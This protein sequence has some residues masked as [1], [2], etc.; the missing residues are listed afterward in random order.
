MA[1]EPTSE[2]IRYLISLQA[3]P[4]VG[5]STVEKLW[6]YFG[7]FTKAW[8]AG[9]NDF[10]A[11]GLNQGLIIKILQAR[12][13]GFP[14]NLLE[15]LEKKKINVLVKN[16]QDYPSSLLKLAVPPWVLF[17]QGKL[18]QKSKAVAVVGT[19]HPSDYGVRLSRTIAAE[20]SSCGYLVVSGLAQG[21]DSA[22]HQAVVN[23]EGQTL[24]ILGW[25]IGG[26]YKHQQRILAQEIL[27]AS[28]CLMSEYGSS[29]HPTRASFLRRNRLIVALTQGVVVIE[30]GRRSGAKNTAR[31]AR[32]MGVP[33]MAIPGPVTSDQSVGCHDLIKGGAI[34]VTCTRDILRVIE[35]NK[36]QAKQ[37]LLG[38]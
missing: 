1:W 18:P 36:V 15:Q 21:I 38:S 22:A 17:Y 32:E 19:R 13:H 7:S 31:W 29:Y 37:N 35:V 34:L 30:A 25:G 24:A 12:K 28:G 23:Q 6:W 14:N 27:A 16:T 8:Y 2:E 11:A 3:I 5:P 26:F 33:V 4:G 10:L 9:N 20:L